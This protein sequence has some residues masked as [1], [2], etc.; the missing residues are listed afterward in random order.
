MGDGWPNSS[1]TLGD[2]TEEGKPELIG[3]A[4]GGV[5]VALNN[6]DGTFKSPK[7]TLNHFGTVA[8]TCKYDKYLLVDVNADGLGPPKIHENWQINLFGSSATKPVLAAVNLAKQASTW[9]ETR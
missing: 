6:S 8:A 4:P 2:L 5:H 7:L 3:F 9:M 1:R